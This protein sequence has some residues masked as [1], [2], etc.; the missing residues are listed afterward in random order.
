MLD[1]PA[2]IKQ[3]AETDMSAVFAQLNQGEGITSGLRKVDKSKMTHKNPELRASGMVTSSS[4]KPGSPKRAGPGAP[5]KPASLTLKK[6]P[7]MALEGNKWV[8]ENFE[9]NNEVIL[10]QVE[11]NQ[12]V[13]IYGCKN[14]TIQIKSKVTTIAM[15]SCTKTGLCVDSLISSL[16]LVNSKS[17]QVQI[18]GRAPTVSLDKVDSCMVYLSKE[19]LDVEILTSKCSAVNILTPETTEDGNDDFIERPVPEQFLTKIV[20]GKVITIAVEHSG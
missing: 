7:K 10:D 11:L 4:A 13:Y 12:S 5:P 14:S 2:P 15:D 1:A 6:P 16:D 9:N 18:L 17:V 3:A 20:D 19:C 8:V